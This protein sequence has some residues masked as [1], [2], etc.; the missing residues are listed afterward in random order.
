MIFETIGARAGRRD[1]YRRHDQTPHYEHLRTQLKAMQFLRGGRRW[2]LSHRSTWN[3]CR[4]RAVFLDSPS[5]S[6]TAT[7][8]LVALSMAMMI[9]Y[10]ARMH[11]STVDVREIGAFWADR[12]ERML[13]RPGP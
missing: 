13:R 10:T 2:L 12:L 9:C 6:L 3:S 1:Y 7:R 4:A 5:W 8:S 11:R